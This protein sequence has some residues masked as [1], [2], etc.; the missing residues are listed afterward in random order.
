MVC[1]EEELRRLHAIRGVRVKCAA[2]LLIGGAPAGR[3]AGEVL[4]TEEGLSGICILDLSRCMRLKAGGVCRIVLDLAPGV[5]ERTLRELF[6]E[7]RAASLSGVLP[8]KLADLVRA[9]TKGGARAAARLIKAMEFSVA[10]TKG[11]RDAQTTSGGVS[12]DEVDADTMESKLV[13]GLFFA[14]EVLDYDGVCGGFNLNWAFRT[15]MKAGF[16]AAR[17]KTA[18][19]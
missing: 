2:V 19:A 10:G 3:A 13:R 15:G 14:G 1:A 4:F 7:N 18:D 9:E 17:S 5:E 16:A 11:W 8:A 6:E 12:L